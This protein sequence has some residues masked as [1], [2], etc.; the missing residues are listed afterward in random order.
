MTFPELDIALMS[1]YSYP[2]LFQYTP[3][4]QTDS[5]GLRAVEEPLDSSRPHRP[6]AAAHV[7]TLADARRLSGIADEEGTCFPIAGRLLILGAADGARQANLG[8]RTGCG[9]ID[10]RVGPQVCAR[11]AIPAG[12]AAGTNARTGQPCCRRY[13]RAGVLRAVVI[14]HRINGIG[15]ADL[16][17]ARAVE[18]PCIASTGRAVTGGRADGGARS[19]AVPLAHRAGHSPSGIMMVRVGQAE[20]IHVG[21]LSKRRRQRRRPEDDREAEIEHSRRGKRN[22]AEASHCLFLV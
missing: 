8:R 1:P 21:L 15:Q 16:D 6:H 19:R 3:P 20:R 4:W 17:D 9:V 10:K 12:H 14:I 7:V 11:G 18:I 22:C 5:D 2:V 13:Y